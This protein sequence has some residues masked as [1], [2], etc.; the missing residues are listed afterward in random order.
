[1]KFVDEAKVIVTAGK[2][3]HGCV[4]FRREIYIP[5]GGPNGGDGGDNK[6]RIPTTHKNNPTTGHNNRRDRDDNNIPARGRSVCPKEV[7]T[8]N[9]SPRWV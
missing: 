8:D 2:G 7:D 6:C 1:M 5:F 9:P 3:G 4:G